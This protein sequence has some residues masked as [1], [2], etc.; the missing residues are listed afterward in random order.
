MIEHDPARSEVPRPVRLSG[1]LIAFMAFMVLPALVAF[2]I[3]LGAW[4][5]SDEVYAA[6]R[7]AST[8]VTNTP[9]VAAWKTTLVVICPIH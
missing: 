9:T 5:V 6:E 8:S 1:G 4:A 3:V 7:D 2:A